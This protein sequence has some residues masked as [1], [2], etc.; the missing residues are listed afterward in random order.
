M[1]SPWDQV[2]G[3]RGSCGPGVGK[4]VGATGKAPSL[5]TKPLP[6]TESFITFFLVCLPLSFQKLPELFFFFLGA[7]EKPLV[8][9]IPLSI[10]KWFFYHKTAQW[11]QDICG[12]QSKMLA[13]GEG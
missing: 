7:F 11:V 9:F 6:P 4:G 13:G 2:A 5:R 10:R 8:I 12:F 1:R 3:R